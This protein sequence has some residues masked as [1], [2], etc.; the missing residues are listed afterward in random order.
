M[1][2]ILH[3]I[4]IAATPEAI[5]EALTTERGL[6]GWWTAD[7]EAEAEPGSVA[8][9]RFGGGAVEF[10]MRVDTM[11]SGRRLEWSCIEGDKVPAEWAGTRCTWQLEPAGEGRTR[12]R[13]VHADWRSSKGAFAM[14]NT[15]WGG[16][17]FRLLDALEGR[18]RGPMFAG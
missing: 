9:F 2:D 6:K 13:F 5:F 10:R 3:E 14:C 8:V 16:L 7:C 17:L 11:E 15:T 12:V 4:T 18:G 1:A